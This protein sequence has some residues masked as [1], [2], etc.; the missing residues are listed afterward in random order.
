[1]RDSCGRGLAMRPKICQVRGML[2]CL[3]LT[4]PCRALIDLFGVSAIASVHARPQQRCEFS[5]PLFGPCEKCGTPWFVCIQWGSLC[6]YSFVGIAPGRHNVD[7]CSA[8]TLGRWLCRSHLLALTGLDLSLGRYVEA[9]A[10]A[11]HFCLVH[12]H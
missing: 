9:K 1:M 3:P 11:N 6:R 8:S 5:R 12:L 2:L 10:L 7:V 4:H